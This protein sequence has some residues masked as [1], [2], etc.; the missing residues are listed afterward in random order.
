VPKSTT[1]ELLE[2]IQQMALLFTIVSFG[3]PSLNQMWIDLTTS[4]AGTNGTSTLRFRLWYQ[5]HGTMFATAA[6]PGLLPQTTSNEAV[7]PLFDTIER[8][9]RSGIV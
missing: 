6:V 7:R 2:E 4:T 5:L 1:L 9:H 3:V 8:L